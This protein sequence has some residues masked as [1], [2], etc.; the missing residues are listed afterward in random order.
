MVYSPLLTAVFTAPDRSPLSKL[1]FHTALSSLLV[2][3]SPDGIPQ[4]DALLLM[5]HQWLPRAQTSVSFVT[6]MTKNFHML[7]VCPVAHP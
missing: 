4:H 3:I 7:H 2:L 6:E 1:L 5:T